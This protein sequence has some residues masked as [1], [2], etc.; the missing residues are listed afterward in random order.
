MANCFARA[1]F[2]MF[3]FSTEALVN[4]I[5]DSEFRTIPDNQIPE[6]ILN[7]FSINMEK[8]VDRCSLSG[9]LAILPYL[10]SN[11]VD[12][13]ET[14]F[15]RGSKN[16]QVF[17]EL[18]QIRDRLAHPRPEKRKVEI[19]INQATRIHKMTDDF[20]EN[21]WPITKIPRDIYILSSEHAE[22]AKINVD[23]TRFQLDSF[24]DGR[25]SKDNWWASEKI[26]NLSLV[27]RDQ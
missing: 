6:Q 23:W 10:C 1:A 9:K 13:N 17:D 16:F 12:W 18:I 8:G 22:I 3:I 4:V 11:P 25:L 19:E 2:L 15:D 7:K 5:L 20:P 27:K 14:F 24:L 21:F 26:E